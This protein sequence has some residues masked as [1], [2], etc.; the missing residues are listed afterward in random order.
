MS[1]GQILLGTQLTATWDLNF[2]FNQI[3]LFVP[4]VQRYFS[5]PQP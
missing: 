3:S 5:D 1:S 4:N 2:F